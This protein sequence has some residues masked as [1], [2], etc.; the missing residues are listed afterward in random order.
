MTSPL[1]QFLTIL[2]FLGLLFVPSALAQDAPDAPPAAIEDDF[3]LWLAGLRSEA[4][5]AG[6]EASL[7][8][9]VL[10]GLEPDDTV[11]EL[12]SAQAEFTLTFERYSRQRLSQTRIRRGREMMAEHSDLLKS[13]GKVY[14]VQPRFVVAIWGLET[15][16]G[17]FIGGHDVIRS[18]ATLA[19]ASPRDSRKAF[20]R[21]ELII[22][23]QILQEGHIPYAGM[24]GSWAGAMGQGQFMPSS[25]K[26]YA[27]DFDGDGRHDIWTNTADILASIA[28]YLKRHQWN[29]TYTW[30]RQVTLPEGFAGH[31][32][33]IA[34]ENPDHGCRAENS[35]SRALKLAEWNAIGV[36]R[37]NGDDLP[38]VDVN[39]A[40]VRPGGENGPAFLVYNNYR[41]ILRY[42]CSNFYALVV[43]QLSDRVREVF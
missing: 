2:A 20:F 43:G 28:N 25:F 10:V 34:Q 31:E 42:N 13:V 4:L 27:Q 16:Y 33:A 1:K 9:Q 30:G 19:Y 6:I 7:L 22:A 11:M 41:G 14:G 29:D 24:Q 35:H 15:N 37:L 23:F 5:E 12:S 21:K 39:A 32:G 38:D 40:L 3:A 17:S 18:L 36:R 8:D 26:E